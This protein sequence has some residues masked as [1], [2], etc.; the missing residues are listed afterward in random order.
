MTVLIASIVSMHHI[1]VLVIAY[2]GG[3]GD[4]SIF[5]IKLVYFIFDLP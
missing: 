5:T 4:L 1:I 2:T 3:S